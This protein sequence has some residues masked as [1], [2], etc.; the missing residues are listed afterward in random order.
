[1]LPA[2]ER[3]LP[4]AAMRDPPMALPLRAMF[5]GSFLFEEYADR[6]CDR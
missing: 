4:Q 5:L 2:Y 3:F 1:M 6:F